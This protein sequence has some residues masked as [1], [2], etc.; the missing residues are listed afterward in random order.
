MTAPF[1]RLVGDMPDGTNLSQ[2]GEVATPY[3]IAGSTPAMGLLL[4]KLTPSRPCGDTM[5]TLD[6]LNPTEVACIQSW[7]TGLTAP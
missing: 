5:P 6:S 2:C 7:A 4:D 3:L 1:D